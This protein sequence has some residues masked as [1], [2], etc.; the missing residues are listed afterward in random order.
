MGSERRTIC[1][2]EVE[3]FNNEQI[4]VYSFSFLKLVNKYNI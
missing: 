1:D 2:K 3:A 4:L